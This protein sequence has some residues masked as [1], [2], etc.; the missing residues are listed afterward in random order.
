[1]ADLRSVPWDEITKLVKALANLGWPIFAIVLIFVFMKE[2][3]GLIR[4]VEGAE[5]HGVKVT[6]KKKLDRLMVAADALPLGP[7]VFRYLPRGG[8]TRLLTLT[9]PQTR[10]T[11]GA[12]PRPKPRLMALE[13]EVEDALKRALAGK[14]VPPKEIVGLGWPDLLARLRQL[15]PVSPAVLD[16]ADAFREVRNLI[17]HG[18]SVDDDEVLRAIDLGDRILGALLPSIPADPDPREDPQ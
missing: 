5:I 11:E 9:G 16:A 1:M 12:E 10:L 14:G 15:G 13:A 4:R 7:P 2:L 3:K 17:V 18:G 6:L 8:Q